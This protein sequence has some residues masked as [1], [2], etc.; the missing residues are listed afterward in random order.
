MLDDP[1]LV[2]MKRIANI[3]SSEGMLLRYILYFI[4]K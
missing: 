1:T 4:P 3:Q 2:D